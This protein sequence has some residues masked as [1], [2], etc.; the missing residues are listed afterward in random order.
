MDLA[1]EILKALPDVAAAAESSE[2]W[3]A[4]SA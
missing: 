3:I 1:S 4:R 2:R